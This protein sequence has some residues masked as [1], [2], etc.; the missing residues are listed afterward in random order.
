MRGTDRLLASLTAVRV[1]LPGAGAEGIE[2]F[3]GRLAKAAILPEGTRVS[4]IVVAPEEGATD[5]FDRLKQNGEE[6][7]FPG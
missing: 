3:L 6:Q 5:A 7:Q 1:F 2:A 4:S